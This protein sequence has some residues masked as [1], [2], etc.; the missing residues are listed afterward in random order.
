MGG[1]AWP[2]LVGGVI[3]LVENWP[4]GG[5]ARSLARSSRVERSLVLLLVRCEPSGSDAGTRIL[6]PPQARGEVSE[7]TL[8]GSG[9]AF[10]QYSRES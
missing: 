1:G 5:F 2:F 3:C 10:S 7:A 9:K 8:A 4:E 6:P